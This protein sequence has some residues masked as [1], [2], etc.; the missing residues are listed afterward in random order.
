VKNGKASSDGTPIEGEKAGTSMFDSIS[1]VSADSRPRNNK[2]G[3]ASGTTV[4]RWSC[5]RRAK[6]T[7]GGI[8]E[9]RSPAGA[10]MNKM[11]VIAQQTGSVT[12]PIKFLQTVEYC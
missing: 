1:I 8:C 12:I 6:L 7:A 11:G 9:P 10:S 4:V 5:F 2:Y 3:R